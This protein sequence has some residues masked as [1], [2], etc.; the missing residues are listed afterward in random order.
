MCQMQL[1][2]P[3]EPSSRLT[4]FRSPVRLWHS[5]QKSEVPSDYD[6]HDPE[7]KQIYRFV[8]TLFSAAQLTAE[9]AIVTLVSGHAWGGVASI[10]LS[11]RWFA[12][13][14]MS[15]LCVWKGRN[16]IRSLPMMSEHRKC[17]A[18]SVWSESF[19]FTTAES[20]KYGRYDR[21]AHHFIY[22]FI[23]LMVCILLLTLRLGI[24]L[25]MRTIFPQ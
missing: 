20:V 7:Q 12:G 2:I 9:C 17:E 18:A 25:N 5:L 23:F 4:V 24:S 11:P 6:K 8:R 14:R 13:S 22:L 15:V 10:F 1:L 16:A 21:K 3:Q 19:T